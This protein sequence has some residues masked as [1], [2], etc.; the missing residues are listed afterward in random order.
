MTKHDCEICRGNGLVR[1]PIY[2][3]LM[4][5]TI[6]AA[7]EPVESSRDYPC[8]ECGDAITIGQVGA[9]REESLVASY[10]NE[11]GFIDHVREGLAH[12]LAAQLLKDGYIKF[13]RGP[14]DD[15]RMRF[16]MVAMVGVVHPSKLDTLEQRIAERQDVVAREVADEAAHQIDNWGSHYGRADILKRDAG[17]MIRDALQI[18]MKRR[19]ST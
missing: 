1:L 14:N 13:R 15:Q 18:V 9:L 16:Q 4:A 10:I 8:P 11:P 3:R 2:R 19:K 17:R 6:D 12:L 5:C 7:P